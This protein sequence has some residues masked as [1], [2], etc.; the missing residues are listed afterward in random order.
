MLRR[1]L[2]T[3]EAQVVSWCSRKHWSTY[4]L[5]MMYIAPA[6]FVFWCLS[7]A[8]AWKTPSQA[9]T[10]GPVWKLLTSGLAA[11]LGLLTYGI[12]M[13]QDALKGQLEVNI[14]LGTVL[15]NMV[16]W[17]IFAAGAY[18]TGGAG[19]VLGYYTVHYIPRTP[20]DV[21]SKTTSRI[22]KQF[23]GYESKTIGA[24]PP[25]VGTTPALYAPLHPAAADSMPLPLV[26]LTPRLWIIMTISTEVVIVLIGLMVAI[27]RR[28]ESF[29]S[30][31]V[32]FMAMFLI[33]V[34]VYHCVVA[35]F[36]STTNSGLDNYGGSVGDNLVIDGNNGYMLVHA[37]EAIGRKRRT[38]TM[39]GGSARA[40]RWSFVWILFWVCVGSIMVATFVITEIYVVQPYIERHVIRYPRLSPYISIFIY[41][42]A[43]MVAILWAR[44]RVIYEENVKFQMIRLH[45]KHMQKAQ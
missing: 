34:L 10:W 29:S 35:F 39:F 40:V 3:G 19:R 30:F 9:V 18:L 37:K 4:A 8:G 7:P 26:Y 24:G 2:T 42:S 21:A 16:L 23:G 28:A 15:V 25:V 44:H 36:V 38:R 5:V 27:E 31:F 43:L 17:Q 11:T 20:S 6:M 22:S 1:R 13:T 33:F 14:F 32:L 12:P 41:A 45:Q